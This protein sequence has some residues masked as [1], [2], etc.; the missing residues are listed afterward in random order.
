M[1]NQIYN[2]IKK[3]II[4]IFGDPVNSEL[5]KK[6]KK[7]KK[8]KL[9]QAT[10]IFKSR[11]NKFFTNC[12]PVSVLPCFLKILERIYKYRLYK[13]LTENNSL[14]NK[15]FGFREGHS[16]EHAPIELVNRIYDS[17]N[18]NKYTLGVSI[19]LPK[20]FDTVNQS[21]LLKKIKLFSIENNNLKWFTSGSHKEKST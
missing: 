3:T 4:R 12:G 19:D 5:F 2:H 6:K 1:I 16:T 15:Q 8:K 10:P 14:F 9:A 11:K 13:Y 20:A 7:K 17:F 18:E 21:I